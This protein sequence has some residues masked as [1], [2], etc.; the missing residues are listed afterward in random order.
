MDL[1]ETMHRLAQA[2][3]IATEFWDWQGRHV[4]V[5]DGTIARVLAALGVDAGSPEAAEQAADAAADH[6]HPLGVG[7]DGRRPC[8]RR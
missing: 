6:G 7:T 2:H 4:T 3:R 5:P 8:P 1:H